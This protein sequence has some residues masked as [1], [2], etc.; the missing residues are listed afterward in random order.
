MLFGGFAEA[1]YG[2]SEVQFQSDI[3]QLLVTT[4]ALYGAETAVTA[5]I[6]VLGRESADGVPAT[7]E[8]GAASTSSAVRHRRQGRDGSRAR[9]GETADRSR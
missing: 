5:A 8:I 7:D 3:A 4:T 2:A 9:R 1:E 6:D